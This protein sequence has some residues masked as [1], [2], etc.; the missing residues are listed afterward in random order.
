MTAH[1][2]MHDSVARIVADLTPSDLHTF[3]RLANL[4]LEAGWMSEKEWLAWKRAIVARLE[5]APAS[6]RLQ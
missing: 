2:R 1:S 6:E 4:Y 5:L 3:L